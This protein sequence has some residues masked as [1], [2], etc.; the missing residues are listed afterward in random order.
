MDKRKAN[1]YAESFMQK[2]MNSYTK[3]QETGEKRHY[4]DYVRYDELFEICELAKTAYDA[5]EDYKQKRGNAIESVLEAL[6]VKKTYTR[7][8]VEALVTQLRY[9]A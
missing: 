7:K 2:S 5:V 8:E 9:L 6:P 1:K 4:N 3:Y